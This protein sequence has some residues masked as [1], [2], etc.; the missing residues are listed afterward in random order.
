MLIEIQSPVLHCLHKLF[1]D[2]GPDGLGIA[3]L[4]SPEPQ[5]GVLL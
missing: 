4:D 5:Q 2:T 1:D 3:A